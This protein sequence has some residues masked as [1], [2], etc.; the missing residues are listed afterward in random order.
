MKEPLSEYLP[1]IVFLVVAIVLGFVSILF[2]FVDLKIAFLFPRAVAFSEMSMMVLL[3]ILTVGFA[4][5]W[6]KGGPEGE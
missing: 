2:I 4:Y 5:E 3:A 6:K 1:I